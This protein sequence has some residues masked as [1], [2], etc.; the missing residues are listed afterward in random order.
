MNSFEKLYN[1]HYKKVYYFLYRLSG[2]LVLA[3]DLTQET[4]L[5]AYLSLHKFRGESR[6][7][8]WL[9]AIGKN[10]YYKYLKK[11]KL[12]L[13]SANLDVVIGTYYEN[14]EDPQEM[15]EQKYLEVALKKLVENMPKKYRDVVLLR[16]YG[17]LSFSEVGASLGISE[18]SAK[19]IYFRAKKQLMEASKNE[20]TM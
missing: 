13:Q 16:I 10:V 17:E 3:E 4:F 6:I 9:I 11:N 1:E 12:G 5:Q 20:I 14:N 18:N 19:V 2:E 15:M 7:D 8:T